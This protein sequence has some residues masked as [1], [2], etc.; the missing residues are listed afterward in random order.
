MVVIGLAAVIILVGKIDF[1]YKVVKLYTE[2]EVLLNDI[3]TAFT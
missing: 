3:H 2:M 1:I